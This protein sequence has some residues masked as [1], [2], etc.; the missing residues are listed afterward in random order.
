[1]SQVQNYKRLLLL[2]FSEF[3]CFNLYEYAYTLVSIQIINEN[4][5]TGNKRAN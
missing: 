1:M 2:E 4:I 3:I 5:Q